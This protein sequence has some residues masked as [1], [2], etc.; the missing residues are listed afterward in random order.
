MDAPVPTLS[1]DGWVT[2]PNLKGD[3]LLSHFFLSEFSQTQ[4]YIGN[5]ASLPYLIQKNQGN[6]NSLQSD[7]E[8]TLRNY[9]SRYFTQVDVQVIIN[10]DTTNVNKS[11][12]NFYVSYND[13]FGQRLSL[14][15]AV[16][17][18]NSTITNI[19]D[20]NNNG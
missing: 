4:L 14:G 10:Q 17:T 2:D 19:I 15:K 1:Q 5:V 8:E 13:S 6:N 20:I 9:F 11:Q 7:A 16:D 3:Y 12:F 18:V